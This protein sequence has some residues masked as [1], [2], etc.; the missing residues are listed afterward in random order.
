MAR[1]RKRQSK[2]YIKKKRPV[3]KQGTG[4][5][6][7]I[8]DGRPT[9]AVY[10]ES[11]KYKGMGTGYVDVHCHILPEVD[12]GAE[13]M[14][15]ALAMLRMEYRQGVRTILLTPH[16]RR[17]FFETSRDTILEQFEK[18]KK[19]AVSESIGIKLYLG[20]EFFR[21]KNMLSFLKN[22]KLFCISET[23]YVLLEFLPDDSEDMIWQ[24]S[25]E[26]ILGGYQ[27]IIAHA[28]RYK[29]I[30]NRELRRRLLELGVYIQVNAGSIIG[31]NG[32]STKRL[33]AKLLKEGRVHF[34]G[35]DAH[36]TTGRV[37]CIGECADYLKK[38][39]GEKET[40]RLLSLNPE[41]MLN[42]GYI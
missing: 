33:C 15:E 10:T 7:Q 23:R 1:Q 12:D 16:Y 35:S 5:F 9:D 14:R 42:G 6:N 30:K 11:E 4:F 20:C 26:L 40:Q 13:N 2:K 22:E 41:I 36:H 38:K 17:G 19:E 31:Y 27:P 37:P 28:E 39:I 8:H 34:V 32:W 21:Q 24:Y 18:L 29:A 25:E 3:P